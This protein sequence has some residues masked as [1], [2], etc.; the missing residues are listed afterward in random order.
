MVPTLSGD[1]IF[2]DILDFK[3]PDLVTSSFS[4]TL[5]SLNLTALDLTLF[6]FKQLEI[7]PLLQNINLSMNKLDNLVGI[8]T[9]I[10]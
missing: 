8:K 2:F 10:L 3:L 5:V 4:S 9:F 6:D 1:L 7:F